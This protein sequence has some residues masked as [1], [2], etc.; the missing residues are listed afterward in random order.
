MQFNEFISNDV[1]G[2][3]R[4]HAFTAAGGKSVTQQRTKSALKCTI[5]FKNLQK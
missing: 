5:K 3:T 4:S 2:Y 1:N